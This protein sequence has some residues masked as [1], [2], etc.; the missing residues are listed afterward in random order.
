MSVIV[1]TN[2]LV[3]RSTEAELLRLFFGLD[4]SDNS[5]STVV[6]TTRDAG[7]VIGS[8]QIGTADG[9]QSSVSRSVL[10][11]V[12]SGYVEAENAILINV[13]AHKIIAQPGAIVYNV[14][15]HSPDGLVVSSGQVLA[16]VFRDDGSQ[17]VVKSLNSI[18][19]GKAWENKVEGNHYSFEEVYNSNASADPAL[20]ERVASQKHDDAWSKI[21]SA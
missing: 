6:N 10:V 19:G 18:D 3:I 16:G 15:D 13:T 17:L 5:T 2:S 4:N 12:R 21:Q 20:L 11:N 9:P 1:S 7:S 14:V 8:S